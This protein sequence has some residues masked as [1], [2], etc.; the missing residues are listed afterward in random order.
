MRSKLMGRRPLVGDHGCASTPTT[1]CP[2][3]ADAFTAPFCLFRHRSGPPEA[4]HSQISHSSSPLLASEARESVTR[5]VHPMPLILHLS[6]SFGVLSQGISILLL[7]RGLDSA[8]SHFSQGG[9]CSLVGLVLS[10]LINLITWISN[11]NLEL[12]LLS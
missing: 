4:P 2:T 5:S 8:Q 10:C 3:T 9:F 1:R 12:E 6:H 11:F 7:G